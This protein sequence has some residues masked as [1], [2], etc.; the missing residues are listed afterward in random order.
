MSFVE[1]FFFKLCPF[2]ESPPLSDV[3]TVV[4][5]LFLSLADYMPTTPYGILQVMVCA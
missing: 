3:P 1:W 5:I 2:W 4:Y